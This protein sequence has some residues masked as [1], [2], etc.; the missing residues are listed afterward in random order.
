MDQ[1]APTF[2]RSVHHDGSSRYVIFDKAGLLEVGDRVT[3]RLRTGNDGSLKRVLLRIIP[4]G[5]QRLI[6]MQ[7][8]N[9][10]TGNA[11]RWW[12]VELP[13]SNP[14]MHYRFLIFTSYGVY[15]YNAR[16]V[17]H[18]IPTESEDFRLLA[19]YQAADWVSE[20]VF[21]QIFPDRFADGDSRINV[22]TGEF[23]QLGVPTFTKQWGAPPAKQGWEEVTEYYGGDLLGIQQRIDYLQELG[24]NALYLNPI[25]KA[26]SNHRYDVADYYEVDS[27][28][29]GNQALINLRRVTEQRGMRY[30][31]DIV[32]NHCGYLHP[33]FQSAQSDRDADTAEYFIFREHP[34]DY[35]CWLGVPFL[36]KLNYASRT[37]R[38]VMYAGE[39]S[40]FRHW[41]RPPYSADGWRID[42]A[43]MLGRLGADQLGLEV[44]REI[45]RAVKSENPQAYLLGEHFFDATPQLQ[46]D[47]WD[48]VM[49]YTGFTHPLLY[50]LKR[51]RIHQHYKPHLLSSDAA[52]T[53]EALVD[54]WR[55]YLSGIPWIIARQQ[56]NLLGSH[57]TER[58]ATY[59]EGNRDLICLAVAVLMTFPGAPCI[60]YGDEIGL[61]IEVSGSRQ[62]MNWNRSSWDAE[63]FN[64][65]KKLV[66]LRRSSKA[67]IEGGF[68]VFFEDKDTFA[69]IRDAETEM[70]I[71]VVHRGPDSL[72]TV[73]LP[74]NYAGISNGTEFTELFSGQRV[75]VR[76]EH[77]SL[78][79]LSTGAEIWT[80]SVPA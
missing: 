33:W 55:A 19:G 78:D 79:K 9:N 66:E 76:H 47:C 44:G 31:L 39:Q 68:Q 46:G 36:P 69:Y 53:T 65:Y 8:E 34:H 73:E 29:G 70:I 26:Y 17:Q 51:F 24:V 62:C 52:W 63:L 30:I 16:G 2:L 11:C 18:H 67:L 25:F 10:A 49:N 59:L 54:T 27:H 42:V 20:S 64:Y 14:I 60:Y 4:D 32:P 6:E 58:I 45:R 7:I 35:E 71:V 56:F 75:S 3:I 15:W 38:D 40:I 22:R 23:E 72:A 41:L 74:V 37:L 12:R 5:E 21:Y 28:L 57:D 50:W 43:N 1:L 61:G 48:G 80:A 13:M 77:L